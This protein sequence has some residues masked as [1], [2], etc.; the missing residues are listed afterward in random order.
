MPTYHCPHIA[1]ANKFGLH[2]AIWEKFA[3]FGAEKKKKNTNNF[4]SAFPGRRVF[5]N[6]ICFWSKKKENKHTA[7]KEKVYLFPLEFVWQG[8]Q[9]LA[10]SEQLLHKAANELSAIKDRHPKI[11]FGLALVRAFLTPVESTEGN[12]NLFRSLASQKTQDIGMVQVMN[13]LTQMPKH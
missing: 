12:L 1:R 10:W 6:E 3:T 13:T 5:Q 4:F 8:V 2:E 11:T 9:M 7:G